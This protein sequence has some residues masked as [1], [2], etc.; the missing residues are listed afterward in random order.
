MRLHSILIAVAL[1]GATLPMAARADVTV[2]GSIGS[3][4]VNGGDFKGNDF[5]YKIF[6][7]SSYE[8]IIGGEI[9]Y[10]DFGHLG[11]SN[12]PRAHAW[13]PAVTLGVPLGFANLY[14][15]FGEAFADVAH[16][17]IRDEYRAAKPFYGLGARFG[18]ATGLGLRVEYERYRLFQE[19]VD[20]AS[21]GLEFRF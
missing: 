9:N 16:T 7:G 11:G 2:G 1:L 17:P 14:G 18:Q 20:L 5:G 15:K 3:A 12:G 21:A 19:N 8:Q 6:V 13:A 4:R 10:V